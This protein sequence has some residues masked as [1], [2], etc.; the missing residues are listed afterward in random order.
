MLLVVLHNHIH[1]CNLRKLTLTYMRLCCYVSSTI[2]T[3]WS[4]DVLSIIYNYV[5]CN[6]YTWI[7]C[8]IYWFKH[9]G[10]ELWCGI[11]MSNQFGQLTN[12]TRLCY[13]I[14]WTHVYASVRVR[15]FPCARAFTRLYSDRCVYLNTCFLLNY[16]NQLDVCK[17]I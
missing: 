9:G 1:R 16:I 5:Q 17:M 14:V 4:C 8:E 15:V 6:T 2:W 3:L 7:L 13:T 12:S 10:S 11:R